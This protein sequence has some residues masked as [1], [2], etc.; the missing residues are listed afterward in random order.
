MA[1]V[2]PAPGRASAPRLI[3][4]GHLDMVCAVRPG[5]GWNPLTDPV[6][7]V[8]EGGFL[9]SDGRSSLGAD[10]HLGNAAALW[11]LSTGAVNHGPLRL[12]FTTAEEVGLEGAKEV[13][14]DWL[15]GAEY[16]LNTDGFHLGRAVVG[17]ASGRRETWA[18]PLDAGPA[19]ALPAW[20]LTLSGGRGGHSGD[21][22]NRGRANPLAAVLGRV[23]WEQTGR[24]LELSAVHVGLEPSVFRA[25][26]PG[27]VMASAGPDILDAH[28]VDERAPLDGLPDYALLLAGAMEA[29]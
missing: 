28:S 1:D 17:S 4:Q 24:T 5:S 29:L 19:P 26:A 18:A 7:V 16:L 21:D 11:L 20:R 15:A 23:W 3:L 14:P 27:L 25:K 2:P 22:I 10:N 9:R 12:L 13:A 8:V 6:A